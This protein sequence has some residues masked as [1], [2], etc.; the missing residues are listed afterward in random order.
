MNR[1]SI[2]SPEPVSAATRA[3][4]SHLPRL[5]VLRAFAIL[6]VFCHHFVGERFNAFPAPWK[7]LGRDYANWPHHGL[8]FYL[9]VP[10]TFAWSGVALFFVLS[11]FCIHY[12]YL[13]RPPAFTVLNFYWRRFVRI[14]PAY[15]AALLA[16]VLLHYVGVHLVQGASAGNFL[17]HLFLVHNLAHSTVLGINSD[18]WSLAVEF[19]FYFLYPLIV[20]TRMRMPVERWLLLALGLNIFFQMLDGTLGLFVQTHAG[21]DSLLRGASLL[22][23]NLARGTLPIDSILWCNP[24][25]TWCDWLL[26]ACLAQSYVA[27]TR[28][29]RR[30][31]LLLILAVVLFFVSDN[32]KF[33]H[34]QSYLFASVFFAVIMDFYLHLQAKLHAIERLFI[35]VGIISYSFYLWHDPLIAE[36]THFYRHVLP[37]HPP[38]IVVM[39][40]LPVTLLLILPIAAISYYLF[41]VGASGFLRRRK[42]ARSSVSATPM[43]AGPIEPDAVLTSE[44]TAADL[45]EAPSRV[46]FKSPASRFHR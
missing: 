15:L 21:W 6:L 19:Q 26:G 16:F 40:E 1:T 46:S 37:A 34:W 25:S 5:D 28:L 41:E 38:A 9:L 31:I 30:P 33:L 42:P 44:A 13:K 17:S 20:L 14:Y 32:F 18:F 3:L 12:A 23:T 4:P 8:E 2:S 36:I 45:G 22:P 35:P 39:L 11:G 7:G 43:V 29:F 24:L 27:G 10:F